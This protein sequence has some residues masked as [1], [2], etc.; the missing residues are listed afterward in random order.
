MSYE[1]GYS[2]SSLG[3]SAASRKSLCKKE[4]E[5]GSRQNH[6]PHTSTGAEDPFFDQRWLIFDAPFEKMAARL[7]VVGEHPNHV[8]LP[9]RM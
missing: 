7:P 5:E 9:C 2:Q 6:P 1:R 8:A 3:G 4:P